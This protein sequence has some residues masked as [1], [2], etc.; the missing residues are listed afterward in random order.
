MQLRYAKWAGSSTSMGTIKVHLNNRLRQLRWG[1]FMRIF[2]CQICIGGVKGVKK[3]L[4][5][6]LYIADQAVIGGDTF[7][8]HNLGCAEWKYGRRDRAVKHWI[9]AAKLGYDLSLEELKDC[10]REGLVSKEDFAA[11]LRAHQAAVDA[12]KSPEKSPEGESRC[13]RVDDFLFLV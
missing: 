10:Y 2:N 7:A 11:A 13:S 9:I 8:R 12:T 3:D 6:E 1:T 5:K 4:K